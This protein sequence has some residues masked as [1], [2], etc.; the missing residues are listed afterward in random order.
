MSPDQVERYKR[1]L[2]VKEIGG[3]GQQKLLS[4]HVLII[5]AG[6]LG[7][8]A[9]Q[10]L[11]ASGVGQLTIYDDDAVDLSNLQ[12]Q[13]QFTTADVGRPKTEALCE[14]L[15]NINPGVNSTGIQARWRAG[16]GVHGADIVFDGSDNFATRFALNEV[17]RA[18]GVPLASGA[19]AGWGG[20]VLLVN[21][22]GDVKCPCYRCFVPEE[23]P[24][25]GDC[26]DLGVVGAVTGLIASRTAL[27]ATRYL[28]DGAEN[29]FGRLWLF[30]GLTGDAR[31]LRLSQDPECP[32]CH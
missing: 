14:R 4:A 30:E 2:L 5:G 26:N 12:R 24:Q 11:A 15:N 3:P 19:V 20:Q 29:L 22:P 27:A 17:S 1:H 23:P 10:I 28:V 8:V 9:A 18:A 32:V 13:T 25:A 16:D 21:K 6:A 31:T 7:G